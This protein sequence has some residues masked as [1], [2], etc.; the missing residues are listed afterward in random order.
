[1]LL[2]QPLKVAP[3][4]NFPPGPRLPSAV[5]TIAWCSQPYKLLKL[6]QRRYGDIFSIRLV[7]NRIHVV[8]SEPELIGRIFGGLGATMP[9]G[10]GNDELRPLL[11]NSSLFVLEGQQHREHRKIIGGIFRRGALSEHVGLIWQAVEKLELPDSTGSVRILPALRRIGIAIITGL[12]FGLSEGP[13]FGRLTGSIDELIQL[14]NGP[15]MYFVLLQKDLG[16][17]SPGGRIWAAKRALL[18]LIRSEVQHRRSN[19]FLDTPNLLDSLL[20]A[21]LPDEALADEVLTVLLAGHDPTTAATAWALYWIHRDARVTKRL[22]EELGAVNGNPARVLECTYLDAVCQETLR[23]CPIV[24]AIERVIREP[25][26]IAGYTL[27]PGIRLTPCIYLAHQRPDVY[28]DPEV[29]S[30]ER[31]FNNRFSPETLLPFGGGMRRCIG[32]EFAP[33][34]MKL[35]LASLLSRFAFK[36]DRGKPVS[37]VLR[38]ATI[39][40]SA[41]LAFEVRRV[42]G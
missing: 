35:V 14:V 27:P 9:L 13:R 6:C 28:P 18:E 3:G 42:A 41:S 16:G 10:P 11:G 15:L 5:Q 30:P 34:Q 24:P 31:F 7:G 17:W 33:Y 38:G 1:M 36:L 8:V 20:R 32:S 19:G 12:V 25:I 26:T 22:L 39:M 21:G 40:P 2:Q 29:F 23:L 37:P 4:I